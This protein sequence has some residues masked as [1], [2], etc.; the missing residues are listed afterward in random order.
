M[1]MQSSK[2]WRLTPEKLQNCT[3][4]SKLSANGKSVSA[5][6][7]SQ[8]KHDSRTWLVPTIHNWPVSPFKHVVKIFENMAL[9]LLE[10]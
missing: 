1:N 5:N 9:S 3:D 8:H 4:F 7:Q 10:N 6:Y 2:R